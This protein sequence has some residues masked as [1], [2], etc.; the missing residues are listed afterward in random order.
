ML[1]LKQQVKPYRQRALDTAVISAALIIV[2]SKLALGVSNLAVFGEKTKSDILL[3]YHHDA[4]LK[5]LHPKAALILASAVRVAFLVNGVVSF[6][7]YL[8][9]LQKN[10]WSTWKGEMAEEEHVHSHSR[11][12][13]T[14]Y[15]VV[16]AAAL[17]AAVTSD[18]QK[19]LAIVGSTAVC[20]LAFLG[21]A[22]LVLQGRSQWGAYSRWAAICMIC[23]GVLQAVAGLIG[24]FTD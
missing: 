13:L 2:L 18:V 14:N 1:S 17:V 16:L 22:T 7:L 20:F 3:N 5:L 8:Q 21:P 9:P 24:A 11:F 6:P 19:P 12:A 15:A 10:L 23:S 4:L